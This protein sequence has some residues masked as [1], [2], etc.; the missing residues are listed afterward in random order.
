MTTLISHIRANVIAY[1][2]LF[3]ALGGTSYAA[4]SIPAGSVGTRQLRN[5][6]VTAKK[7]NGDSI[8]GYVA[9]WA[10]VYISGK[11]IASSKAATTSGWSN[12]VGQITFRGALPSRCFPLANSAGPNPV[13]VVASSASISASTELHIQM[14]NAAGDSPATVD[15]A[16]ICS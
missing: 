16:E 7:L 10:K 9:F 2:A 15:V 1:L 14:I 11:I 4:I 12:G 5:G 13:Y 8:A 6:A 3:V